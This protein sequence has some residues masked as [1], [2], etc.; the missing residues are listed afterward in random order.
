MVSLDAVRTTEQV[1]RPMGLGSLILCHMVWHETAHSQYSTQAMIERI[2]I[3]VI[4]ANVISKIKKEGTKV[5]QKEHVEKS[6]KRAADVRKKQLS[7]EKWEEI[8]IDQH[9]E[10]ARNSPMDYDAVYANRGHTADMKKIN[11]LM[12]TTHWSKVKV[13]EGFFDEVERVVPVF[14]A[15]L[16]KK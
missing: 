8:T 12:T 7:S 5:Q 4:A 11:T 3:S 6:M 13:D 9:L 2:P 16:K 15:L 1:N 10:R 14:W